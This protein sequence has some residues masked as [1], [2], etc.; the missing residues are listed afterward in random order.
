MITE[1]GQNSTINKF[2]INNMFKKHWKVG[3]GKKM[4]LQIN[5][6]FVHPIQSLHDCY[7]HT[8]S[9]IFINHQLWIKSPLEEST[10]ASGCDFYEHQ[11]ALTNPHVLK[12]VIASKTFSWKEIP[13]GNGLP[14][15]QPWPATQDKPLSP[16]WYQV[17]LS[18]AVRCSLLTQQLQAGSSFPSA[19]FW[20]FLEG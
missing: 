13:N 14:P 15:C 4:Y 12:L 6:C 18:H 5:D 9:K 16:R 10:C 2:Y 11:D 8:D 20:H 1:W 3:L 17:T 7:T 19:A